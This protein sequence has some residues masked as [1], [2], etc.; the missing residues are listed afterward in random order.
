M[1][2]VYG[3]SIIA[4]TEKLDN[5]TVETIVTDFGYPNATTSGIVAAMELSGDIQ[6]GVNGADATEFLFY[7]NGA[8]S[9]P[10]SGCV[11]IYKEAPSSAAAASTEIID[12][13]C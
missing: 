13:G 4:G 1:S 6:T 7:P 12:A 5:Q 3:K 9:D 11:V 10:A 8:S 2:V